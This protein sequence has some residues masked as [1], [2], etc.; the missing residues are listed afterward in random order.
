MDRLP[1]YA[2]ACEKEAKFYCECEQVA[3]CSAGCKNED[4]D[5]HSKVCPIETLSSDDEALIGAAVES[6]ETLLQNALVDTQITAARYN[7]LFKRLY[8]VQ[9]Y[10]YIVLHYD[11]SQVQL[12]PLATY[13]ESEVAVT[14]LSSPQRLNRDRMGPW[15]RSRGTI[16]KL[17]TGFGKTALG[18]AIASNYRYEVIPFEKLPATNQSALQNRIVI[19]VTEKTLVNTVMKD[20]WAQGERNPETVVN[21]IE[22][23]G[24]MA[25]SPDKPSTFTSGLNVISYR[26]ATNMLIGANRTGR[27]LWAG[28]DLDAKVKTNSGTRAVQVKP[29]E[30]LNA[31][32][33]AYRYVNGR[34]IRGQAPHT[35]NTTTHLR[36]LLVTFKRIPKK[37]DIE[38]LQT[39]LK[40]KVSSDALRQL[41]NR[42]NSAKTKDQFESIEDAE[43]LDRKTVEV[44][45][46]WKLNNV[47]GQLQWD[48]WIRDQLSDSEIY[49]Q[50]A[51]YVPV[52]EELAGPR[53]G[54][55]VD[56]SASPE[57]EIGS[58]ERGWVLQ[59]VGNSPAQYR[60][61]PAEKPE[62]E[63]DYNPLDRIMFV[64][65]EGDLVFDT[66]AFRSAEKPNADLL[67]T[68]L[69]E[70]SGVV[71]TYMSATIDLFKAFGML[72]TL[73]PANPG[74]PG[75]IHNLAPLVNIP[76]S[77]PTFY[78]LQNPTY[79]DIK[80]RLSDILVENPGQKLFKNLGEYKNYSKGLISTAT[81][82]NMRDL[83]AEVVIPVDAELRVRLSAQHEEDL[84]VFIEQAGELGNLNGR[85]LLRRMNFRETR[86]EPKYRLSSEEFQENIE[87][88]A[89]ELALGEDPRF[90]CAAMVLR[91]LQALDAEEY[92]SYKTTTIR[93]LVSS[94]DDDDYGVIPLAACM[95]AAGYEWTRLER[96]DV[97]IDKKEQREYDKLRSSRASVQAAWR[98]VRINQNPLQIKSK[99]LQEY[100]PLG[101]ANGKKQFIVLSEKLFSQT[102]GSRNLPKDPSK[103]ADVFRRN[104]KEERDTR[105][106]FRFPDRTRDMQDAGF[107]TENAAQRKLRSQLKGAELHFWPGWR[108]VQSMQWD[109][110]ETTREILENVQEEF[111]F[112]RKGLGENY[113]LIVLGSAISIYNRYGGEEENTG[114]EWHR[115]DFD[116]LEKPEDMVHFTQL[117]SDSGRLSDIE[118]RDCI[119]TL[120][121]YLNDGE[122]NVQGEKVR[123][124]LIGKDFVTGIDIFRA[125]AG[126]A[127]DVAPSRDR[128]LQRRGRSV[129]RGGHVGLPYERWQYRQY[130]CVMEL[131]NN[132]NRKLTPD[133]FV[134]DA[135]SGSKAF[136]AYQKIVLQTIEYDPTEQ[137]LTGKS[138]QQLELEFQRKFGQ[139][140]PDLTRNPIYSL[141]LRSYRKDNKGAVTYYPNSEIKLYEA[142]RLLT[143]DPRISVIRLWGEL[144]INDWSVD[145]EHNEVITSSNGFRKPTNYCLVKRKL[146]ERIA[147][148]MAN[149]AGAA[150]D[151]PER[152]KI[153][154]LQAVL[155]LFASGEEKRKFKT[156]T[157]KEIYRVLDDEKTR[158]TLYIESRK[159]KEVE[160]AVL[161]P[162][163]FGYDGTM[164]DSNDRFLAWL[165]EEGYAVWC[166]S[167]EK[168]S[169]TAVPN[170]SEEFSAAI[171]AAVPLIMAESDDVDE[172]EEDGAITVGLA[173]EKIAIADEEQ[174][175]IEANIVENM[176][177]IIDLLVLGNPD[178]ITMHYRRNLLYLHNKEKN[179][180]R[181]S[182]METRRA[183]RIKRTIV[184][185]YKHGVMDWFLAL[186]MIAFALDGILVEPQTAL[187]PSDLDQPRVVTLISALLALST[188]QGVEFVRNFF[189]PIA[190][191]MNMRE[192]VEALEIIGVWVREVTLDE[193]NPV[194]GK[195]L[196]EL[197]DLLNLAKTYKI[198]VAYHF[199]G[200]TKARLEITGSARNVLVK[201]AETTVEMRVTDPIVRD[202]S[203]FIAKYAQT[204]D[205]NTALAEAN[206]EVAILKGVYSLLTVDISDVDNLANLELADCWRLAKMSRMYREKNLIPLFEDLPQAQADAKRAQILYF[207]ARQVVEDAVFVAPK[208]KKSELVKILKDSIRAEYPIERKA[209][210]KKTSID[211]GFEVW[212][213]YLSV[214]DDTTLKI[215]ASAG[216][217]SIMK[218]EDLRKQNIKI[219]REGSEFFVVVGKKKYILE[220]NSQLDLYQTS[221]VKY[222]SASDILEDEFVVE[223]SQD[224]A[225]IADFG[226]VY[227][228]FSKDS[229]LQTLMKNKNYTE[230]ISLALILVQHLENDQMP[231]LG[232]F[233]AFDISLWKEITNTITEAFDVDISSKAGEIVS[234]PEYESFYSVGG[235][236][237]ALQRNYRLIH[238]F[239]MDTG[240]YASNFN[241]LLGSLNITENDLVTVL[242]SVLSARRKRDKIWTRVHAQ[243]EKER[244]TRSLEIEV[245]ILD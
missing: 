83:F 175:L 180:V 15:S 237:V 223:I 165:V 115:T 68:A 94:V 31:V 55:P 156:N 49:T 120:F 6:A 153:D 98:K 164:E 66:K 172:E 102:I 57:R 10:P 35:L 51:T 231:D 162:A 5:V 101:Y 157:L 205:L 60:W 243:V 61:V 134:E 230:L 130:T 155:N 148:L 45:I 87:Q 214:V 209:K 59:R 40:R 239:L 76:K 29:L 229:N 178:R 158:R 13:K 174:S 181:K 105:T 152:Q 121:E 97:V 39:Q 20:V 44:V 53:K 11:R 189:Q 179:S 70:S 183:R 17:P 245:I 3:Y 14:T 127:I 92:E 36:N 244:K 136:R 54:F 176:K 85:T 42:T 154:A 37:S 141:A 30:N 232:F 52:L 112:V 34:W 79:E 198:N 108:V 201:F 212:N 69:R 119:D 125:T 213:Q 129:R 187:S 18:H 144:E 16:L 91:K 78:D 199:V 241:N 12:L 149:Q 142:V 224:L 150:L 137:S 56:F 33:T 190:Q 207:K 218:K 132:E 169:S 160:S 151:P 182:A 235:K 133:L 84:Y 95:Q 99:A 185:V 238:V 58:D 89:A 171:E 111:F 25:G 140:I 38:A 114:L 197:R 28:F 168:S 220:Q 107:E 192:K 106:G 19:W 63:V 186:N 21:V 93:T 104:A 82:D 47:P 103:I 193:K 135:A 202:P 86:L 65:D 227:D 240:D 221:V 222:T 41:W 191:E 88:S 146:E 64:F 228:F 9:N 139:Y 23:S 166:V 124:V 200:I 4:F 8:K 27:M 226:D 216:A 75:N 116:P 147:V 170:V 143:E 208:P 7:S 138:D 77:L 90:P 72:N 74:D 210:A 81:V 113:R 177:K 48:Q 195:T 188:K 215:D 242:V 62:D 204:G 196:S 128:E 131:P 67:T 50:W 203:V 126:I 206:E 109:R 167:V 161:M 123:F 122:D 2:V 234:S 1:C 100:G 46:R 32:P 219:K 117:I 24:F 96:Q 225:D 80:E 211:T 217:N 43:I 110:N 145:K 163:A 236:Q 184:E 194:Y 173:I 233:A 22:E 26:T 159:R 118:R 73:M 71:V